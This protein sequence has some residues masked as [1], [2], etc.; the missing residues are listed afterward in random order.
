MS[1]VIN[2]T[3]VILLNAVP[4][5]TAGVAPAQT[6]AHEPDEGAANALHPR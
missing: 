2:D 4:T 6:R 5:T 3:G 1:D